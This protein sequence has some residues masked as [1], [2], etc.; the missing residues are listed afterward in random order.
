MAFPNIQPLIRSIAFVHRALYRATGG[1]IGSSLAGKP[2]LLLTTR[3]RKSGRERTT[4]LLYHRDG[5]ALVVVASNGGDPRY[6]AWYLNLRSDPHG[7]VQVGRQTFRC[8]ARVAGPEERARLWPQLL[9]RYP[10]Y[11]EYEKR[12]GR[13][14]PVVVLTPDGL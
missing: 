2:M 1:R 4:P 12:A 9:A 13:E 7:H 6:P 3:G 8:A 11:A 10:G 5:D 14:I